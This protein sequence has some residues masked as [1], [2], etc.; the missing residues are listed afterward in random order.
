MGVRFT[1]FR[2]KES[3]ASGLCNRFAKA[4][5]RKGPKVQILHFPNQIKIRRNTMEFNQFKSLHQ[6]HIEDMFKA[7]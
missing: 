4:A 5:I 7:D 1:P 2:N 3:C 6:K